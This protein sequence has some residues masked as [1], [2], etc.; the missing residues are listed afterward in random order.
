MIFFFKSDGTLIKSAPETVYQGSAEAGK[1]YVVAPLNANMLVDVY[2]ELPNGERWGA[3]LLENNGTV[4]NNEELPDGWSLWSTTLESAITQYA[5]TLKAQFGF[6][7]SGKADKVPLITSQGVTITI[8]KGV[9]RDLPSAPTA[10]VY[11]QIVNAISSIKQDIANLPNEYLSNTNEDKIALKNNSAIEYSE[12]ATAGTIAKRD[13]DGKINVADGTEDLNAVNV[14]GLNEGLGTKVTR[15]PIES[16]YYNLYGEDHDGQ[17][18]VPFSQDTGLGTISQRT[19]TGQLKAA[20][21]VADDDLATVKQLNAVQGNYTDI[22]DIDLNTG[23]TTVEYDTE[24]GITVNAK[25][26]VTHKNGNTEQPTTKFELPIAAGD[27]IVIDKAQNEEKINVKV[28]GEVT[29]TPNSIVKRDSAGRV[30]TADAVSDEDATSYGQHKALR[31]YTDSELLKKL[32]RTGGTITGNLI[33]SGNLSVSG[34]ASVIESTTLK[35]ADKLIYV[36]KDNTSALTSPAGLITPKY[37]GT[38]DGGIVY[39]NSGTAYVGDIKL[40]SN[41][42]VDVNNSDLQPI[43]TRDNYSNFTNGHKV[44]VEV[45]SLQKSVKFVDGGKDDGINTLTDINLTLGD[46]TVQY[47]TTDGIQINSTARFTTQGTNHDAMMDL[48]LPIIGTDGIVI[49]K[50][51]DSE[52]IQVSGKNFVKTTTQTDYSSYI[53]ANI[54]KINTVVPLSSSP[55]GDTQSV[56]AYSKTTAH[57]DGAVLKTGTPQSEYE[58][59]NKKYVDDGFV[60]KITTSTQDMRVYGVRADGTQFIFPTSQNVPE[61]DHI[62]QYTTGGNIRTNTPIDNLDCANKKYVDEKKVDISE[63]FVKAFTIPNG[64]STGTLAADVKEKLCNPDGHNYYVFDDTSQM[65]LK[66]SFN[67]DDEII[68]YKAIYFQTDKAYE[69]TMQILPSNGSWRRSQTILS[70]GGKLYLHSL[71]FPGVANIPLLT[72]Y[73]TSVTKVTDEW[74]YDNLTNN[75]YC[76]TFYPNVTSISQYGGIGLSTRLLQTSSSPSW[77]ASIDLGSPD[78]T[79]LSVSQ[80]AQY[81]VTE[82]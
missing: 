13:S 72:F 82:V 7:Q 63:N 9:V 50:A 77:G 57:T 5:G 59:T 2:Y 66:Y 71:Y 47:D 65:I 21:G 43:A 20:D 12:N 23:D 51:A 62:A 44:K 1:V 40:D 75:T 68:Q 37:D 56:A 79:T 8:A 42:N 48:A 73:H 54:S 64:T 69:I 80:A 31:T 3:Y 74:I 67:A 27:G 30:K 81:I 39:D 29:E 60:A 19:I 58:C 35:V 26:T 41:G 10:D 78:P 61:I 11:A 22:T 6:Y 14:R 55:F 34:E 28:D 4:I 70:G 52:K 53:Y 45:D 24:L 46:T 49:D 18:A 76:L 38:N 32:D 36:A 25:G 16:G 15:V 33:V 17:I